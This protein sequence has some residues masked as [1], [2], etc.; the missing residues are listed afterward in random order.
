MSQA[1][2]STA[3]GDAPHDESNVTPKLC[4]LVY[5]CF[6]FTAK[7]DRKSCQALSATDDGVHQVRRYARNDRTT[8]GPSSIA[9]AEE[10][11]E[12][13]KRNQ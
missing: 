6:C 12:E 5:V 7:T 10:E 3:D 2:V 9:A 1:A 11:V 13:D 4:P 8:A